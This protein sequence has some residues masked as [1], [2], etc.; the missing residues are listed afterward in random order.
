MYRLKKKNSLHLMWDASLIMHCRI[1]TCVHLIEKTLSL[2][3]KKKQK[4][5]KKTK[6]MIGPN[7]L[8]GRTLFAFLQI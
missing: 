7:R 1:V 3:K 4:K 6:W 2:G 8:I 5:Q